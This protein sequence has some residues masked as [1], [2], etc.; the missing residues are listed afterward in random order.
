ML[1]LDDSQHFS[2]AGLVAGFSQPDSLDFLDIPFV[3]SGGSGA[4]TVS[5]SSGSGSGTLTVSGGGHSAEITL[6]GQYMQTNFNIAPD[7]RG[8]TLVFDPPVP[9]ATDSDPLAPA[10]HA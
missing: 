5:W 10:Q 7:G 3:P 2:T 9:A 8:G 1:Q 6:L 4:T